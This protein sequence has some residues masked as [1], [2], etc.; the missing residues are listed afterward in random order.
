MFSYPWKLCQGKLTPTEFRGSQG[1][2]LLFSHLHRLLHC[3]VFYDQCTLSSASP[4][5]LSTKRNFS[6]NDLSS[7]LRNWSI[8]WKIWV[9]NC[10]VYSV[11]F[12]PRVTEITPSDD[13]FVFC[14]ESVNRRWVPSNVSMNTIQ[15]RNVLQMD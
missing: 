8:R 9:D 15:P 10:R 2:V 13:S 12:V 7:L 4:H 3:P 6:V 11:C 5:S 1:R 14:R